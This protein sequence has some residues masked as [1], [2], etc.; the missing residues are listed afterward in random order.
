V[1]TST[2]SKGL[3]AEFVN[4]IEAAA[5]RWREQIDDISAETVGVRDLQ[6][7]RVEE[8]VAGW[9]RLMAMSETAVGEILS[10][11][12]LAETLIRLTL[13][14][15]EASA[16]IGIGMDRN[17]TAGPSPS[18]F[19]S[20]AETVL[21]A[22][23]LESFCWEVPR[24]TLCVLGKQHTPLKGATFRSLSHHLAL[25]QPNEITAHWINPFPDVIEQRS[26]RKILNLL[27][28][29]WPTRVEAEDF[30]YLP[31]RELRPDGSAPP[32]YFRYRPAAEEGVEDFADRLT[33]ALT[34]AQK[35]AGSIDAIVLPELALTK[36]QYDA[37]ERI[38]FQARS[39]L[40]RGL[41]QAGAHPSDWDANLSVLQAAGA[42]RGPEKNANFDDP[43]LSN[44]RLMQAK[45]H[46]W[47][48]DRGQIVNYQLGGYFSAL[49][50]CWE[51]I[52]LEPP[53][54]LNFVT[55]NGMTWSVL[56][57]EDLPCGGTPLPGRSRLP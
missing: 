55:L 1:L 7:A 15:D 16:G 14:A 29:P 53:R 52:A 56:V 44:L 11:P 35:H 36:P 6:A 21:Y 45:H 38:A 48:L 4:G 42:F 27:L 47:Y 9:A 50:G 23:E 3:P 17:T 8:V 2:C 46:R 54:T 32:G 30:E 24:D 40:V 37:A 57:C 41:R 31:P 12:E 28:L 34:V 33:Q 43:L 49:G 20:I 18:K 13:I 5:T 25:Y 26:A 10:V 51:R 19:L 39:I 22:N